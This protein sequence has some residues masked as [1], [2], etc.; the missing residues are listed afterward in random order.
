MS[1]QATPDVPIDLAQGYSGMPEPIVVNPAF[2][3]AVE[4]ADQLWQRFCAVSCRGHVPE[5]IQFT[6]QRFGTRFQPPIVVLPSAQI[7]C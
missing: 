6:P 3:V 1:L 2:E 4:F 5:F 7:G